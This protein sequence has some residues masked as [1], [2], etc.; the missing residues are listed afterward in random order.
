MG[1]DD[2]DVVLAPPGERG[3]AGAVQTWISQQ[4]QLPGSI[5]PEAGG[6]FQFLSN[7]AWS[8]TQ[9]GVLDVGRDDY[10]ANWM[11]ARGKGGLEGAGLTWSSQQSQISDSTRLKARR[12]PQ[13]DG[14]TA[15]G[16]TAGR[17][18]RPGRG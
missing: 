5:R 14:L 16:V 9:A 10:D 8:P 2:H 18:T 12:P 7:N 4:P 17:S 11:A 1:R 3:E 13:I 15:P 6:P